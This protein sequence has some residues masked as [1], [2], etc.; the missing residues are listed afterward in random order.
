MAQMERITRIIDGYCR[1]GRQALSEY[2]S[3]GLLREI[4]IRVP[5]GRGF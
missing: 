1:A 4:G 3:K 5:D 2:A